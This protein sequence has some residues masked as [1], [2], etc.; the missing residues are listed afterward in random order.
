MLNLFLLRVPRSLRK[1]KLEKVFSLSLI[2]VVPLAAGVRGA[3]AVQPESCLQKIKVTDFGTV[4]NRILFC[5]AVCPL[6]RY[7]V[8]K[9]KLKIHGFEF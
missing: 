7:A 4:E 9:N 3:A 1:K 6:H 5:C 2:F 8:K